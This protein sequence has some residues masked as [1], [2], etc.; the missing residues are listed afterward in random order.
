MIVAIDGPAGAGK[1]TISRQVASTLEFI[2]LDTGALY[3]AVGLA[4]MK[5][6]RHADADD[7]QAFVEGL[8][9]E[10]SNDDIRLDGSNVGHLIRT[11]EVSK[12]AS[13]FSANPGVRAGLL[14]LQR[15]IGGRQS[16]V[17]DGRDIGTVVF[18]DAAVKVFLTASVEERARRRWGELWA[19]GN[20]VDLG[21]IRSEISARDKAD[22]ERAIAPLKPADDAVII[23]STSMDIEQVV[24]QILGLVQKAQA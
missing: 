9:I 23:D 11:P 24:N 13:Q 18:P 3:R 21:D 8:A 20:R 16:A 5:D 1:T 19:A 10:F 15:D 14:S 2:R 4:A 7:L 12:A 22:S 17:V 6:G